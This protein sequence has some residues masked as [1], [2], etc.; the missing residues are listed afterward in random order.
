MD[1]KDLMK[2][3]PKISHK[4]KICETCQQEKQTKL[5]FSKNKAWR[6]DQKL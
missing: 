2:D 1:V 6:V 3:L 4:S 5:P